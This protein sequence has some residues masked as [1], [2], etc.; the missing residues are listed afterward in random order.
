MKLKSV[1]VFSVVISLT[2]VAVAGDTKDYELKFKGSGYFVADLDPATGDLVFSPYGGYDLLDISHLGESVVVWELRV[3]P[4]TFEFRSGTFTIT[5]S[6]GK[7][8]LEGHY[9]DFQLGVGEYD[10]DWAF[11]G[12]TGRF[13]DATGTGHTDGLVDLNPGYAQFEFSG[14]VTTQR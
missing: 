3:D 4:L 1:L 7:D 9:S 6:N 13:G 14:M 11:T 2:L 8:T 12:G 10:L 5:G